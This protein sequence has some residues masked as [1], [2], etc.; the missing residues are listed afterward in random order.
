M[1]GLFSPKISLRC[2]INRAAFIKLR[3][4]DTMRKVERNPFARMNAEYLMDMMKQQQ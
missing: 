3:L 2:R 1:L 4:T